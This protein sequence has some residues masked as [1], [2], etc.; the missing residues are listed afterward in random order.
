M[1]PSEQLPPPQDRAVVGVDAQQRIQHLVLIRLVGDVPHRL[2]DAA[3]GDDRLLGHRAEL[4]HAD[5][6]R[7]E[8]APDVTVG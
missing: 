7:P 1:N 8:L 2:E 5:E 4:R 3:A 6:L